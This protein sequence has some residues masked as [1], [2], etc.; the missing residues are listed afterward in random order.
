MGGPKKPRARLPWIP[1]VLL[2][3]LVVVVFGVVLLAGALRL[4]GETEALFPLP[5]RY[6]SSY[7]NDWGTSREQGAHE[8]TDLYAP[9][10]TPIFSITAGTVAPTLGTEDGWN[11]LGGYAVTIE[12]DDA[13][14]PM[15]D[16]DS[17]YYAHLNAPTGLEPGDRV[18]AGQK[19]GEVGDSGGGPPGTRGRFV[20]H[21][22]LGWY[23]GSTFGSRADAPSGA[24]NPY[25]LLRRLERYGPTR[26]VTGEP[27]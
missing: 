26:S 3:A 27:R 22:H 10:G 18:E 8:G 7:E 14:A 17:L 25:P 16:G 23:D 5:G 2:V 21:L 4:N 15:E 13:P 9:R 20:T 19:I 24:M 6:A 11:T 1:V 12:A